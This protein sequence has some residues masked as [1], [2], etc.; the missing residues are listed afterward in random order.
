M[1]GITLL[2]QARVAVPLL[3][4][5]MMTGYGDIPTAFEAGKAGVAG[6]LEKPLV[7]KT[8]VCQV[9]TLL[10]ESAGLNQQMGTS[11]TKSELTVLKLVIEGKSNMEIANLLHRSVRTVEVHRK[12]AREKLGVDNLI[13]L[14]KR[15]AIM[16]LI[17]L[18]TRQPSE[19]AVQGSQ[20]RQR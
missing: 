11:L 14:V 15:A 1:D 19:N 6:F 17:D 8:L 10:A 9:K 2:K 20:K 3:P 12:R 16:G 18:P 7:K 4:V 13:D 5:L